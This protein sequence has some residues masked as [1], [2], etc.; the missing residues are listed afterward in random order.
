MNSDRN[1]SD[2]DRWLAAEYAL[3][4]LEQSAMDEAAMRFESD[5]SFRYAVEGWQN[6]FAPML[7]GIE[8]KEPPAAVWTLVQREIYPACAG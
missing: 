3:G 8:D 2:E 5:R 4:V 1:L 7:E 6:Q